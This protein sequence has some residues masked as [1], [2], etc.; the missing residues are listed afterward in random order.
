MTDLLVYSVV[1]PVLPFQLENLGYTSVSGLVGWL[2]FG[3]VGCISLCLILL[4]L[5]HAQS[6]G[7]VVCAYRTL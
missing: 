7:L 2:L 4:P 5:I 1:I 3:Y 6:G